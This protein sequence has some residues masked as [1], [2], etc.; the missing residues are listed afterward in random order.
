MHPD[1]SAQSSSEQQQ[2]RDDT[3]SS[4]DSFTNEESQQQCEPEKQE[5]DQHIVKDIFDEMIKTVEFAVANTDA[6]QQLTEKVLNTTTLQPLP[7]PEPPL[8]PLIPIPPIIPDA[9]ESSSSSRNYFPP[10]SH[11]LLT[12]SSSQPHPH[13]LIPSIPMISELASMGQMLTQL[14]EQLPLQMKE[15]TDNIRDE[16]QHTMDT[17]EADITPLQEEIEITQLKQLAQDKEDARIALDNL[18]EETRQQLD[19]VVQ[20]GQEMADLAKRTS[21]ELQR[22]KFDLSEVNNILKR[23]L[24]MEAQLQKEITSTRQE[25]D[26]YYKTI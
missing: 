26:A 23:K 6:L 24:T 2:E 20:C 3:T 13:L 9:P 12:A 18:L 10:S 22:S 4:R 1:S 25:R 21:E 14:S 8:K 7:P 11:Q 17:L 16:F 5:D 19:E 15:V